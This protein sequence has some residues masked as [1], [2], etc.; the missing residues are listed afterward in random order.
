MSDMLSGLPLSKLMKF[1][2]LMG[3]R[4]EDLDVA[5]VQDIASS[6]GKEV[7]LNEELL[8][9]GVALLAGD[10]IHTVA[11]MIKSPESLQALMGFIARGLNINKPP[12]EAEQT[13]LDVLADE[14][15]SYFSSPVY[16]AAPGWRLI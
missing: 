1:A 15:S 3:K 12:L 4:L 11:D 9:A 5:T 10:N 2:P 13:K 14:G 8:S 7:S 16:T 6:L